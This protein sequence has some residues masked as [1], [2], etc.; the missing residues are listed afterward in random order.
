MSYDRMWHN[1]RTNQKI[2]ET[3]DGFRAKISLEAGIRMSLAW[4]QEKEV[5][6]R[7]VKKYS[8]VLDMLYQEYGLQKSRRQ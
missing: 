2:K 8:N 4:L 5:R 7:I 3:V 1:F 6:R